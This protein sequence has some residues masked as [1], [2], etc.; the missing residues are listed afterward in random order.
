MEETIEKR[1]RRAFSKK[2][3]EVIKDPLDG[4]N[5]ITVQILGVCSAL[6][7]TVQIKPAIIMALGVTVVT[8]FPI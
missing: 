1:K 6:A 5:P 4:S 2:N 8:A 3:M 7:V